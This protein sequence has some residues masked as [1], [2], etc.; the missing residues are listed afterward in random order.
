VR[1]YHGKDRPHLPARAAALD[2]AR[3]PVSLAWA[4]LG[5]VM[6]LALLAVLRLLLA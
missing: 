2:L 5:R 4:V 3:E 6:A 1:P